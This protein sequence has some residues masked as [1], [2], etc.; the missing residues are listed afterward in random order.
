MFFTVKGAAEQLN[1]SPNTIYALVS[2]GKLTCN[3]IGLG[4]G[5]IRI[6]QQDLE[7]FVQSSKTGS[8][9]EPAQRPGR[10]KHIKF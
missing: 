5:A 7:A 3:R 2:N 10:M 6:A 4:R 8:Q 1:V 9:M